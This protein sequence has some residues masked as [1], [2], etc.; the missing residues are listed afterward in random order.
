MCESFSAAEGR[1]EQVYATK[2]R[3]AEVRIAKD[4]TA[5]VRTAEVRFEFACDPG[6]DSLFGDKGDD[7]HFIAPKGN[8]SLS[9]DGA[10]LD[11][12]LGGAGDRILLQVSGTSG[13]WVGEATFDG[14][15]AQVRMDPLTK[16][17]EVDS[18]GNGSADFEIERALI[19]QADQ[20]TAS[21]F[22]F[23]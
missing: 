20:L 18:D 14:S 15:D 5:K 9:R 3:T 4:R 10:G 13:L 21:D 11:V 17:L 22:L 19:T 12:L 6:A 16:R 1:S 2:V 7:R 8:D 23:T